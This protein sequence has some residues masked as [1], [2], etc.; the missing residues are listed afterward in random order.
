MRLEFGCSTKGAPSSFEVF[1]E[2]APLESL[3]VI[4]ISSDLS[5]ELEIEE[6]IIA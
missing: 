4:D 3:P 2:S 1:S 6:D 5:P